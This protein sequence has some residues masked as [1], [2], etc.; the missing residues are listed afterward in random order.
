[1]EGHAISWGCS[2]EGVEQKYLPAQCRDEP[3]TP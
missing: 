2:G 3:L 1:V